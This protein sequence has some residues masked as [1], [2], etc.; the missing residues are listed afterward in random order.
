MAKVRE[1]AFSRTLIFSHQWKDGLMAQEPVVAQLSPYQVE[2]EKGK[3]YKWCRCGRSKNQPFCDK[4]HEGTGLT[5][6]EFVA[7]KDETVILCGCK[8]TGDTP[9]CDGTHNYF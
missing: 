9:F 8:E 2:I 7:D 1:T 6:F 4:S 5:P 3:S